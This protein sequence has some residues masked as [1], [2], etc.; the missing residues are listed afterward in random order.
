MDNEALKQKRK[1][2]ILNS[3]FN[4]CQ[5]RIYTSMDVLSRMLHDL[6]LIPPTNTEDK[7][8]EIIK[9]YKM[10]GKNLEYTIDIIYDLLYPP[11][12]P[13]KDKSEGDSNKDKQ[14]EFDYT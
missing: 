2:N 1:E 7:L 4:H 13:K 8:L 6:R 11:P 9:E 3:L 14:T 10:T 12:P 5:T